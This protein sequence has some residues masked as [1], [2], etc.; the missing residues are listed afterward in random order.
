MSD[1]KEVKEALY[2]AYLKASDSVWQGFP[3]TE[4][5]AM[6]ANTEDVENLGDTVQVYVKIVSD[7]K[8]M[9]DAE[10]VVGVWCD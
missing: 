8:K 4:S 5:F 1:E 7:N 3:E 10:H 2:E 9:I 6:D